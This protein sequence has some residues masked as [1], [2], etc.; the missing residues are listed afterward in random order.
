[1]EVRSLNHRYLE[2]AI[3]LPPALVRHEMAIREAVAKKFERGRIDVFVTTTGAEKISLRLNKPLAREISSALQELAKDLGLKD[4]ISI[5]SLLAWKELLITEEAQYDTGPM[6]EALGEAL[7]GVEAMRLKEG[8]DIKSRVAEGAGKIEGLNSEIISLAPAALDVAKAKFAERVKMMLPE[9]EIDGTKLMY[10]AAKAGERV[11]ISE[12]VE[13]IGGH[14]AYLRKL[15]SGG[16]KIGR[17]LD[18]VLQEL[19]RETNTIAS[20]SESQAIVKAA[21]VMKAE[22]ESVRE[23]VQNIQ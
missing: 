7:S 12:E 5:E 13:R 19:Y 3:K 10:E 16:G 9:N 14:I 21:V 18:F 15:I 23:Q 4:G 1:M 20:K 17:T 2:A 8:Q 22:I 11:D 6:F